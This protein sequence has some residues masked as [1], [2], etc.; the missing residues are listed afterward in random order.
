MERSKSFWIFQ[1]LFFEYFVNREPQNMFLE[2]NITYINYSM[3][4]EKE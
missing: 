1:R 2:I 3:V 4:Y